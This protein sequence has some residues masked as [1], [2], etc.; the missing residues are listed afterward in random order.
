MSLLYPFVICLENIRFALFLL[1]FLLICL[2]LPLKESL[3]YDYLYVY[4]YIQ[5]VYN[6]LLYEWYA[7]CLIYFRILTVRMFCSFTIVQHVCCISEGYSLSFFTRN[8]E[9]F[10]Q[11]PKCIN[12]S[13]NKPRERILARLSAVDTC[14]SYKL[15]SCCIWAT[16]LAMNNCRTFGCICSQLRTIDESLEHIILLKDI[17]SDWTILVMKCAKVRAAHSSKRGIVCCLRE[18]LCFLHIIMLFGCFFRKFRIVC[19]YMPHTPFEMHLYHATIQLQFHMIFV[20]DILRYFDLFQPL[21]LLS[22]EQPSIV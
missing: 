21:T 16:R 6:K 9:P 15:V 13:G 11:S 22:K 18:L 20:Y 4:N 1:V 8:D 17:S 7:L 14:H 3:A 19:R 5:N 12:L 2:S 10:H